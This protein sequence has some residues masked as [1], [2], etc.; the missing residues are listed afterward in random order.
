MAKVI[1]LVY[2]AKYYFR[3]QRRMVWLRYESCGKDGMVLLI[4][5][6][7]KRI[8]NYIMNKNML[9]A[10]I[11]ILVIIPITEAFPQAAPQQYR[12]LELS[13]GEPT[14]FTIVLTVANL[15]NDVVQVTRTRVTSTI[16]DQPAMYNL[17]SQPYVQV[18]DG[19]TVAY[20]TS[21]W[22][23]PFG[24][25]FGDPYEPVGGGG[26][27]ITKQS[28]NCFRARNDDTFCRATEFGGTLY[29][30]PDSERPCS[31]YCYIKG[32]GFT[33]GIDFTYGPAILLEANN[34]ICVDNY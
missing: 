7:F 21:T 1:L 3:G 4:N 12:C 17:T 22:L 32:L 34:V 10:V 29:C 11:L 9:L 28:C 16:E 8:R 5:N 2:Y 19:Y 24:G 6:F 27:G 25:S 18:E 30:A 33:D 20:S 31:V 14:G 15:P 13:N 23:V 26:I